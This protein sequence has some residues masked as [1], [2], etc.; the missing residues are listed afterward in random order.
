M[1]SAN[2]FFCRSY[3][4]TSADEKDCRDFFG[5]LFF[6]AKF[7]GLVSLLVVP[8]TR[9][10]HQKETECGAFGCESGPPS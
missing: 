4:I 7:V 3:L 6:P 2:N 8:L 10:V 1:K 9:I 5:K